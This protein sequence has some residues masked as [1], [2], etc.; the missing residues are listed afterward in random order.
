MLFMVIVVDSRYK[1]NHVKFWSKQW[2]DKEKA[3]ELGKD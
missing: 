1:L 3:Y 2:Y